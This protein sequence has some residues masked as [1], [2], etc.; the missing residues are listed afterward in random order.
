M[1]FSI[2][3][4]RLGTDANGYEYIGHTQAVD[5]LGNYVLEPEESEAVFN[6]LTSKRCLKPGRNF[7]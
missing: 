2:G 6:C 5:Y 1:S 7:F 3:V 4:N